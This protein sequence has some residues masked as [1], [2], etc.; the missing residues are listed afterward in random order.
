MASARGKLL[1]RR[2]VMTPAALAVIASSVALATCGGSDDSESASGATRPEPTTQRSTS[3]TAVAGRRHPGGARRRRRSA[4]ALSRRAFL[5]LLAP[6]RQERALAGDIRA[7][8]AHPVRRVRRW[9]R[10]LGHRVRHA[11]TIRPG[12][13]RSLPRSLL[14]SA[15]STWKL[16]IIPL[17]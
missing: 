7:G 3:P 11:T 1:S 6:L 5:A 8:A 2:R 16:N 17:S 4:A 10:H 13:A 15:G 9:P 14:Y 12:A